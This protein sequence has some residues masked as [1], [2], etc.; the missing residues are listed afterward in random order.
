MKRILMT[1]LFWGYNVWLW[2]LKPVTVGVQI[3]LYAEGQVILVRHTYKAGW[4]IPAGATKRGETLLAAARREAHEE[5]GAVLLSEPRLQGI[6]SGV[7]NTKTDH[8]VVFVSDSFR[9]EQAT[10]TWEIA[11]C[12]AFPVNALPPDL[13]KSNRRRIEDCVAGRQGVAR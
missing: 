2:L 5:V 4:Y 8:V 13:H 12:R 7:T 9:L 3:I 11:E 10:D 6:Y 1:L